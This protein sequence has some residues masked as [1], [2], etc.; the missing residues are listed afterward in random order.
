MVTKMLCTR[1]RKR[2]TTEVFCNPCFLNI[3]EQ[4]LG[5]QLHKAVRLREGMSLL[6][7]DRAA[8]RFL[9]GKKHSARVIYVSPKSLKIRSWDTSVYVNSALRN[10]L[11]KEKGSVA[12]VPLTIDAFLDDILGQ[13]F[14]GKKPRLIAHPR[15]IPL[16]ACLTDEELMRYCRLKGVRMARI[17]NDRKRF[18]DSLERENP[19][20]KHSFYNAV[21]QFRV[22]HGT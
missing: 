5:K 22:P 13:L 4:R 10:R 17:H 6:V 3:V 9:E 7:F 15:I 19:G 2:K 1:C 11:K 8:L 20:T 18:L 14:T 21:Q 12:I 16:F